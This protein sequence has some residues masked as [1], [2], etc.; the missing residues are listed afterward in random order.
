MDAHSIATTGVKCCACTAEFV[1]GAGIVGTV[2]TGG[3][4][5]ACGAAATFTVAAITSTKAQADSVA[6]SAI[7]AAT[8]RTRYL[9]A[10]TVYGDRGCTGRGTGTAA[11]F[12]LTAVLSASAIFC[13]LDCARWS[14]GVTAAAAV[15]ISIVGIQVKI[16]I[17]E[18][19][20]QC[21]II[22]G[23]SS[24]VGGITCTAVAGVECG[25]DKVGTA[26]P[27]IVVILLG[28]RMAVIRSAER[29]GCGIIADTARSVIADED[30]SVE[31]DMF[32][33]ATGTETRG[34]GII[35][36]EVGVSAR[37][38][39]GATVVEGAAWS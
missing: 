28:E 18:G 26:S 35:G 14:I 39:S 19:V 3:R 1:A 20:V 23:V 21:K 30:S 38:E 11:S 22:V 2:G 6:P 34:V 8:A 37:V 29:V 25:I 13:V 9:H 32:I 4:A 5:T 31:V 36:S 15:G 16:E 33:G 10:T 17:V 7:V 12:E 24:H 27:K